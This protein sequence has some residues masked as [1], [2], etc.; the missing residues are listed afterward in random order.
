MRREADYCINVSA[1]VV[2][3]SR[4]LMLGIGG[5]ATLIILNELQQTL[6]SLASGM[7]QAVQ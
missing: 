3:E 2:P 1:G 7:I 4:L 6:I 5:F